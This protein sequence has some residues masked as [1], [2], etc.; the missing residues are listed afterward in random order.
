[1]SDAIH[2]HFRILTDKELNDPDLLAA[3]N[4]VRGLGGEEWSALLALPRVLVL[5]EAGAGKTHE[6]KECRDALRAE[7]KPAFFLPLESLAQED[8]QSLLS[9]IERDQL[10]DWQG[11]DSKRAWFLL[12]SVDEMKLSRGKFERAL[13]RLAGALDGSLHRSSVIVTSRPSDW[14]PRTDLE[15]FQRLLPSPPAPAGPDGS[16]AAFM[17]KL[18][19]DRERRSEGNVE[20]A[21]VEAAPPATVQAY[22]L[23]PLSERQ[24]RSFARIRKLPDAEA[25]V[26][27][28]EA[29]GAWA[30]AR[31]PLDLLDLIEIWR[32]HRRLGS[33]WEQVETNIGIKLRDKHEDGALSEAMAREG[34]SRLALGL[35]LT[36]RRTL[37]TGEARVENGDEEVLLDP[38]SILP[39]WRPAEIAGLLRLPMFDPATYGRVRFHHRSVAEYMAAT[40]IDFLSREHGLGR[41]AIDRLLFAQRYGVDVVLPSMRAVAAW[42]ALRLDSVRL[43]IM[44]REPELLLLEGDPGAL[45]LEHRIALIERVNAVYGKGGWRRLQIPHDA[46]RRISCPELV[47]AIRGIW[48]SRPENTEISEFMLELIWLGRLADA[49]DIALE[50]ALDPSLPYV[51]RVIASRALVDCGVSA[52][53]VTVVQSMVAQPGNWDDQ[54]VYGTIATLYPG[55]LSTGDL[56][57]LLRRD[58]QRE[59]S[60]AFTMAMREIVDSVDAG[61]PDATA[62]RDGLVRLIVARIDPKS[63]WWEFKSG[64]GRLAEP[65]ARLVWRQVETGVAADDGLLLAALYAN[66]LTRRDYSDD[67]VVAKLRRW[68]AGQPPEVRASLFWLQDAVFRSMFEAAPRERFHRSIHYG[69]ARMPESE[70]RDWLVAEVR[71]GSDPER[72]AVAVHALIT[73]WHFAGRPRLERYRLVVLTRS[74]PELAE[75][76]AKDA[77]QHEESP[78]VRKHE[79]RDRRA[80]RLSKAKEDKRRDMWRSWRSDVIRD[81]DAAFDPDKV[82]LTL[83]SLVNWL[84]GRTDSGREDVWDSGAVVK[85]FG[86]AIGARFAAALVGYWKARVARSLPD[87]GAVE[88]RLTEREWIIGFA[89]LAALSEQDDWTLGLTTDEAQSATVFAL[90]HAN[91]FPAWLGQ[92]ADAR[93]DIVGRT[94]GVRL[95]RS[96]RR[97]STRPHIG[98]LQHLQYGPDAARTMMLPILCTALERWPRRLRSEEVGK[99]WNSHLGY[100]VRIIA[101]TGSEE[102]RMRAATICRDRVNAALGTA[103]AHEWLAALFQLD[104]VRAVDAMIDHVSAQKDRAAALVRALGA[105]EQGHRSVPLR[106]PDDRSKV[107]ALLRAVRFTYDVLHPSTD[108]VR[109]GAHSVDDREEAEGVRD[110]LIGALFE[111]PGSDAW[112]AL[113]EL[114]D[115]PAF[116]HFP[117]RLR[118]IARQRAAKDADQTFLEPQDV[119]DLETRAEAAP[120]DTDTMH[121]LVAE[122]LRELQHG[123]RHDDFTNRRTL[124]R[125]TAEPEMQVN[126][127]GLLRGLSRDAYKVVREDEAA[128]LKKTDIRFL[129]SRSRQRAVVEIKMADARWTAVQLRTALEHQLVQLYLRM[130]DCRSGFLLLVHDGSRATW[131][132]PGGDEVDIGGLVDWLQREGRALCERDGFAFRIDTVALD[133]RDPVLVDPHGQKQK[134]VGGKGKPGS[135]SPREQAEGAD[136]GLPE[137]H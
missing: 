117:D 41:P 122:R 88:E 75:I 35:A 43:E 112:R 71:T 55:H 87:A 77:V 46:G 96:L 4:E 13:E 134:P 40:R 103:A 49:S 14:R 115:E 26:A 74:A 93:P 67:K 80:K 64:Q 5:A 8:V 60:T 120:H 44:R 95:Y 22:M 56:L 100:V 131:S 81:A 98:T 34:A 2:R 127:A 108:P 86:E 32:R 37:R 54:T 52:A 7:G 9:A 17:E 79:E 123:L 136:D 39:A 15:T 10:A 50:A 125:V 3:A 66:Q 128:D 130:P 114:A 18:P 97:G 110:F 51:H 105:V 47:P 129:S 58:P 19:G 126:L 48:S 137:D 76:V 85:A 65:L 1:M 107:E 135:K 83:A 70:D 99:W 119:I 38:P 28:I 124:R 45:T 102:V 31:R 68:V 91:Q 53:I 25:F 12:D 36:R 61:S 118:Q 24:I 104:G 27:A 106:F 94:I 113:M 62:L 69:L 111:T 133:L 57:R 59:S 73:M 84:R 101:R 92:L 132:L 30:F 33:R 11:H 29:E 72:R 89:G 116:G 6:L 90:H 42:L 21:E 16:E 82:D 20:K 109:I 121:E 63:D 23:L 78:L